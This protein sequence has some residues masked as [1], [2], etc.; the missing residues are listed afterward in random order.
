MTTSTTYLVECFWPD[1][2]PE[3]VDAGSLRARA[4][5]ATLSDEGR[6]VLFEG[7]ILVPCDEVV[8]Y[9]FEG[10][11]PDAVGE[12]CR[13]AELPYARIVESIRSND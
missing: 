13:R 4:S 3:Q 2:R 11:S 9:L 8:F 10:V 7:S 6:H 1:V 12:A 5:A